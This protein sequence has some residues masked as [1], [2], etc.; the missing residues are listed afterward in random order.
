MKCFVVTDSLQWMMPRISKHA[1]NITFTFPL[2]SLIIKPQN[3]ACIFDDTITIFF[4]KNIHKARTKS[5]ADFSLELKLEKR[6]PFKTDVDERHSV[7]NTRVMTKF[8]ELHCHTCWHAYFIF[9]C[10]RI[11][12]CCNNFV[13]FNLLHCIVNFFLNIDSKT[14]FWPL[15]FT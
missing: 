3:V 12:L 1:I 10:W 11:L 14:T 6:S 15:W 2:I 13:Y 9:L 5:A 4:S 7:A 8:L